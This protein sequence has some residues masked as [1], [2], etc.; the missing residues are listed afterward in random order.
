M[1]LSW[2]LVYDWY[3][4]LD[5]IWEAWYIELFIRGYES[6]LVLAINLFFSKSRDL[7]A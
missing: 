5:I 1:G 3:G 6:L 2:L 4:G 7:R